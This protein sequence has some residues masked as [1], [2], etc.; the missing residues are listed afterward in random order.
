MKKA[1]RIHRPGVG[2]MLLL[3]AVIVTGAALITSCSHSNQD[4]NAVAADT[5]PPLAAR[6]DQLDG[7]VGIV[8]PAPTQ[9]QSEP[10]TNIGW[11][12]A[13]VNTPV[14]VGSRVYVKENSKAGIAFSGRNYARLNPNTSLDVLALA[15]RRTQL[16]LRQGSC[17]FSVGALAPDELFE[18]GT[19]D[20]AVDFTQPGLYQV[21]ID[22]GGGVLVS[23]LSGT[24]R[25]VDTGG[26]CEVSKGQLVTLAA[27]AASE[28]IVSQL[29]PAVAGSICNDYYSYRYP[30]TY[31]GRYSD[32]NRY[33]DD[34]YYYDP[35]RRSA[36]Y[37]Y[38]PDDSEVA[39]L[40]DLDN[41]GDWSDVPS[42]GHCWHPRVASGWAPYRDGS[43]S[44]DY[45]LGLTWVASERWGWAPYHYG[46]WANVNQSWYWV[47]SE[48]TT[49]PVYA[50]AL[51]AFVQM[52]EP[53][54]VAWL[55]LGPGDP[56]VPRYYDRNYEAQ[57]AGSTAVVNK[58]VNVTNIVNYHVPGAVTVV[59]TSDFTRVITPS[60]VQTVDPAVLARTRPVMDPFAVPGVRQLAP[61]MMAARPAVAV[62]VTAEQSLGRPV[63]ISQTPVVPAVAANAVQSL[64]AQALPE[65]SVK[66]KL[67][68]NSTGQSV[69]A[70]RPDGVPISPVPAPQSQAGQNTQQQQNQT[71]AAAAAT[72]ERQARIAQLAPQAAGGNKAAKQEMRQLQDQQRIQDKMDRKAAAQQG[73]SQQPAVQQ[74]AAQQGQQAQSP[75][76][77]KAEKQ[78]A[79]QQAQQARQQADQQRQAQAAQ[80]AAQQKAQKQAARQQAQQQAQQSAAQQEQQRQQ[81]K[82]K[83]KAAQQQP[84]QQQSGQ[85]ATQQQQ[86]RQQEKALQR[87]QQQQQAQQAAQQQQQAAAQ[88]KAARQAQQQAAQQQAQQAQQQRQQQKAERRAQQQTTQQTNPQQPDPAKAE[89]KAKNKNS[90]G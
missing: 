87:A 52:P 67:K 82:A 24:A 63:V 89:R 36:S 32:Y 53:D 55:P 40:D 20:G 17:E 41:Y 61:N 14:S 77:R 86:Q 16:A 18:V 26:A 50:P 58:Y 66:R 34:P 25:V 83:R 71:A 64:K 65:E 78:A 29:S 22:D 76:Q 23:C 90:G 43:W 54:R 80:L 69:A 37:Q 56:Y 27:A 88:R 28:A 39:G 46:R 19:P 11:T 6:V 74:G 79:Q 12:Q 81:E 85:A 47:P 13:S 30:S 60:M 42:Y 2:M 4:P 3:G 7:T 72:Q 70:V 49:R 10:Q 59:G 15:Q 5:G 9:G 73:T 8:P 75:E 45:P 84:S 44:D 68:I 38:I 31:D 48:V 21:G 62:P 1:K 57:Y 33:L 51:V 35:Y